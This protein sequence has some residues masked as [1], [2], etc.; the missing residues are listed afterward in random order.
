MLWSS[1]ILPQGTSSSI[2]S[3][4]SSKMM[5]MELSDNDN[6][7]DNENE[8]EM[9]VM[10]HQDDHADH[11]DHAVSSSSPFSFVRQEVF[12]T[13][14]TVPLSVRTYILNFLSPDSLLESSLLS[15]QLYQECHSGVGIEHPIIPVFRISPKVDNSGGGVVGSTQQFLQQMQEYQ[16]H[17]HDDDTYQ[18]V[19]QRYGSMEV[20][21]IDKFTYS[22]G[23]VLFQMIHHNPI[24]MQ[25][26]FL[27]NI[28]DLSSNHNHTVIKVTININLNMNIYSN[29]NVNQL[30]PSSCSLAIA[31]SGMLPNL[32]E[33]NL[34]NM[35]SGSTCGIILQQFTQHCPLLETLICNHNSHIYADGSEIQAATKL[36]E[37]RMD[38]C[39]FLSYCKNPTIHIP[40][41]NINDDNGNNMDITTTTTSTPTTFLFHCWNSTVLERVSIQNATYYVD[42]GDGNDGDVD[43]NDHDHDHDENTTTNIPILLP[44]DAIMKYIRNGA[45]PSL[46]WFRCSEVSLSSTNKK[47]LQVEQ[48][49]IKFWN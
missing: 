27:L 28:Y 26:V 25:G 16:Q 24:Q 43:D 15:K 38:D 37:I 49:G 5:M 3:S 17:Q 44:E 34:S 13:F 39:T 33:L 18:K 21:D 48:P 14:M 4:S 11:A 46:K 23:H 7:N 20:I 8:N 41:N 45:P 47:V 30:A 29:L 35:V 6:D 2:E 12:T 42:S 32:R 9:R 19:T 40:N 36:T 10:P 1:S 31:L 22:I